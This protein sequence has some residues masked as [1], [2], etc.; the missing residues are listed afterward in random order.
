MSLSH[1]LKWSFLSELAAK[2]IQPIVFVILMRFLVPEDFGVVAAAMMVISFSQ[3]FWEAGM[4]KALVQYQGERASAANSAFWV[5]CFLGIIAAATLFAAADLIAETVFHDDRITS[6]LKIMSLQVLLAAAGSVHTAL[7]QKDMK[8][9]RLFWVRFATVTVPSIISI[10]LAIAGMGY[11]ALVAGTLFGHAV[12]LYALWRLSTWRPTFVFHIDVS[13]KLI[14]FGIWVG[15]SG[16]LSWF[17]A[18]TDSLFVGIYLG[19]DELGMYRTGNQFVLMIYALMFSPLLPVIYSFFSEIQDDHTRVKEVLSD[20]IRIVSIIAIPS[21]CLLYVIAEPMAELLFG[22]A[23]AGIGG[24]IAIAGLLH[25][26]SWVVGVNGEAYRAT[27][28]PDYETKIMAGALLF[29]VAGYWLSIRYGLITFLW[30]RLALAIA[31]LFAHLWIAKIALGL[32]FTNALLWIL[33]AM[34]IGLPLIVLGK[35]IAEL[36]FNH[37]TQVMISLVVGTL[38][39]SAAIYLIERNRLIPRLL[40]HRVPDS[41]K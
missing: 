28:R 35:H 33:T 27:G 1:A 30:T 15:L 4:G 36:D 25:G 32:R 40:R 20:I 26:F 5:N 16:L 12:Q 41:A 17:Y 31:A 7:L 39:L 38:W 13:R 11:W 23:W 29:Y 24:V 37:W 14:R 19:S 6:V 21:A 34:L 18:W 2:A 22:T 3:I 8:F 9:K 10:P